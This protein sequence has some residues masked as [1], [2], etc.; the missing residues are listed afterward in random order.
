[1]AIAANKS[2]DPLSFDDVKARIR[3]ASQYS[4]NSINKLRFELANE[5]QSSLDL[6]VT[7]RTFF[8]G[9]KSVVSCDGLKYTL[10]TRNLELF[11]GDKGQHSAKYGVSSKD[12]ELGKLVFS[13]KKPFC[14]AELAFLEM[15]IGTVFYPLR[16]ALKYRS[17]LEHSLVDALTGLNNRQALDLSSLREV[18]LS[19]RHNKALSLLVIDLDHFK[20]INDTYGHLTGDIVLKNV[21]KLI[22]DTLRETDQ[23]FRYG[24]E[25]FV[26]LL[27]ET[28]I[29]QAEKSAERIR[30]AIASSMIKHNGQRINVTASIGVASLTKDDQFEGLFQRADQ[31]LYNAKAEGRDRIRSQRI[32]EEIKKTA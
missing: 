32:G 20:K 19:Q 4:D 13:R 3:G 17:A 9:V 14:E 7:L 26:A 2:N 8:D 15:M 29:E 25:E 11:F 16:N 30:N 10:H 31:A 5:L 1:M 23:V 27:S 12:D 18:K 24:G 22:S 6:E 28:D 21:A